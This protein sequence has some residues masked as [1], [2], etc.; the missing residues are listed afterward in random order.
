MFRINKSIIFEIVIQ[1]YH[2]M[3]TY[4]YGFLGKFIFF[5]LNIPLTLAFAGY[6]AASVL[7]LEESWK[8]WIGIVFNG[9]MIFV[10]N[11]FYL[12]NYSLFPGKIDLDSEKMICYDFAFSQRKI[13]IKLQE[14]REIRGGIFDATSS[15]PFYL[16]TADDDVIGISRMIKD[17]KSLLT[18]ILKNIDEQLYYKLLDRMKEIAEKTRGRKKTDS[19]KS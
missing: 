14:I 2:S 12:R 7:M 4:K 8:A 17:N 5:Y 3:K 19:S 15:R 16:R 1:I 10:V 13:E 18:M 9:I 6:L 11:A